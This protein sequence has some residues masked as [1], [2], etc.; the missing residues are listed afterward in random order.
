M[1]AHPF[2]G[3]TLSAGGLTLVGF[4]RAAVAS[5][6]YLPEVGV[7]FDAGACPPNV[8]SAPVCF[9]SHLHV[10]HAGALA[11][12]V[13]YRQMTR[14]APPRIYVPAGTETAVRGF[15]DTFA[16]LQGP[17]GRFEYELHAMAPGETVR[18]KGRFF[19]R[20]FRTVHGVPSLGFTLLERRDK[21]LRAF[22][23]LDGPA[24]AKRKAAGE[25]VTETVEMARFTYLL[26]TA[27]AGLDEAPEALRADAV[28]AECTF[29]ADEH[30][31]NARETDH[32][33]IQDLAARAAALETPGLILTHFSLRYSDAEIAGRVARALPPNLA[34]RTRLLLSGHSGDLP[35]P[36]AGCTN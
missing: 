9:V 7:L 21:L 6:C 10:D 27:P 35:A 30:L 16:S 12:Y 33:H 1:I 22:A 8:A 11:S 32:L 13:S 34:R 2:A 5:Y 4:S 26:D 36:A 3:T 15:L 28:V 23:H 31:A 19:V 25:Q 14:M 29:L 24:I 18:V 20:A 17:R